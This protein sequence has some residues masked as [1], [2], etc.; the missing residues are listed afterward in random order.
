MHGT[1]RLSGISQFECH[2]VRHESVAVVGYETE[3]ST[4]IGSNEQG[5][6]FTFACGVKIMGTDSP[7]PRVAAEIGVSFL[8]TYEAQAPFASDDQAAQEFALQVA[9][10]E[11]FPFIRQ[12][13]HD[14]ASNIGFTGFL[15]AQPD[16][17]GAV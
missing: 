4:G 6:V 3:V 5:L 9:F 7:D 15:I 13:I 2:A 16:L 1:T 10:P 11:V 14:L 12:R 17:H 8:V